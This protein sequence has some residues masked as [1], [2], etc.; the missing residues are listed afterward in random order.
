MK[1]YTSAI[2]YLWNFQREFDDNKSKSPRGFLIKRLLKSIK[3]QQEKQKDE[4][5]EDRG[6]RTMEDATNETQ[7]I[8]IAKFFYDKHTGTYNS[9]IDCRASTDMQVEQV[10][11]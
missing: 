6:K 3:K 1:Q 8:D 10:L 4:S 7:H 11:A 9:P 2:V 5:F